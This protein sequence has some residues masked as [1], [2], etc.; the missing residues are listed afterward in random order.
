VKKIAL[1]LSFLWGKHVFYKIF[2]FGRFSAAC[3]KNR[4]PYGRQIFPANHFFLRPVWSYFAEFSAGW[5][6]WVDTVIN[7]KLAQWMKLFSQELN[8]LVL[9]FKCLWEAKLKIDRI[10]FRTRCFFYTQVEAPASPRLELIINLL[11][12]GG[13]MARDSRSSV[14]YM[15]PI[16]GHNT[17]SWSPKPETRNLF[18]FTGGEP[19]HGRLSALRNGDHETCIRLSTGINQ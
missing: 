9:F 17:V 19:Q 3:T 11:Y 14:F 6:Q 10:N 4:R 18:F 15:G 1:K 16:R 8:C 13:T 7:A 12:G 2:F 5:Q